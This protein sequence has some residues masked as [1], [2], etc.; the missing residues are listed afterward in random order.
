VL[1]AD[2]DEEVRV[3][4]APDA[5]ELVAFRDVRVV[6]STVAALLC[7]IGGRQVWLPRHHICGKLWSSGDRGTLFIR[8]W[9][10]LDRHLLAVADPTALRLVASTGR[11][12]VLRGPR[13]VERRNR[14]AH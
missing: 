8:R 4:D 9:V 1:G 6:R 12:S 7:R 5:D 13:A 2:S 11:Q 14:R 3:M 10:A